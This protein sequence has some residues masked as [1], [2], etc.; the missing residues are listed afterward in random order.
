MIPPTSIDGTD[1]TGATID[2]T[3]VQEIT[4]DGDV[5]FSATPVPGT[6][7]F[8]NPI[9]QYNADSLNLSNNAVV[10]TWSCSITGTI[11]DGVDNPTFKSNQ[12]GKTAVYYGTDSRHHEIRND[13]TWPI[14]GNP[15]SV[16]ITAYLDSST[17]KQVAF[18][19]N[20]NGGPIFTV[21][22]GELKIDSFG[23]PP[24]PTVGT[25]STGQWFT[26]GIVFDF[27]TDNHDMYV[28]T[29]SFNVNYTGSGASN[30]SNKYIGARQ[31][32]FDSINGYIHDIVICDGAES[33]QSFIDYHNFRI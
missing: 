29:N 16:A 24:G 3:D 5:V 31:D 20:T 26:A 25:I 19:F 2:G 4:V 17:A 28:N 11:A 12:S 8:N 18:G 15:I 33:Q 10:S 14:G 1:I 6:D 9:Q 21:G 7:M 13:I 32:G 22:N 30:N 27:G 23:I